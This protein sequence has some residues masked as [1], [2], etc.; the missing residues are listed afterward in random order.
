MIINPLLDPNAN[1]E[2]PP[3]PRND[4]LIVAVLL[5]II[6]I[7]SGGG[8]TAYRFYGKKS[9]PSFSLK[10]NHEV[11]ELPLELPESLPYLSQPTAVHYSYKTIDPKTRVTQVVRKWESLA[12]TEDVNSAFTNFFNLNN[13]RVTLYYS[14]DGL[15]TI[16]AVNGGKYIAVSFTASIVPDNT[17]IEVLATSEPDS[18]NADSGALTGEVEKFVERLPY[19]P[20]GDT[21]EKMNAVQDF[22]SQKVLLNWSVEVEARQILQ[23]YSNYLLQQGFEVKNTLQNGNKYGV[24]LTKE[25]QT[26]EL[27]LESLTESKTDINIVMR[28]F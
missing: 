10:A 25:N 6:I 13:W 20:K 2:L 7:I 3:K 16:G 5:L 11:G 27:E 26:L 8:Y 18:S 12:R 14:Q 23:E 9:Q 28:N 17:V 19:Y 4:K 15:T 21:A 22:Q 24:V 1:F